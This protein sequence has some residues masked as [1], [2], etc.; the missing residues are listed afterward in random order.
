M[1]VIHNYQL[2]VITILF[3]PLHQ[4]GAISRIR[5][6][7]DCLGHLFEFES[8]RDTNFYAY[9]LVAFFPNL[10]V[11]IMRIRVIISEPV[12]SFITFC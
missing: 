7:L 11:N 3:P 6:L 5:R 9:I 10:L 1:Y 8:S 4:D 12:S 2:K